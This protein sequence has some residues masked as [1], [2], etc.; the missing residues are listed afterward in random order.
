MAK[1]YRQKDGEWVTPAANG[2]KLSCCDCC[3]VHNVDFRVH[4]GVIQF[5]ATRNNRS[6]ALM[7]SWR[8]AETTKT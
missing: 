2:Y 7:R 6:T 5:R 4:N 8:N 1:Y 3:L